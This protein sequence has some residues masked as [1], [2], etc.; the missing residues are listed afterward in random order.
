MNYE[1]TKLFIEKRADNLILF[2]Y[3]NII[4]FND[5]NL[6]FRAQFDALVNNLRKK[7]TIFEATFTEFLKIVII[8][9]KFLINT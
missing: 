7:L 4:L 3:N 1:T 6:A 5:L 8:F 9:I 2:N